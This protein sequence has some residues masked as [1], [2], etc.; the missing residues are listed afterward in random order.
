MNLELDNPFAVTKATEFS[1]LEIYKQWVDYTD[2]NTSLYNLLNPRELMPKFILGSKGCGKTH[3]LRYYSYP[4]QKLKWSE[5][6]KA[7]TNEKYI[8]IYTVFGGIN[9]SRFSGKGIEDEQW[10]KIFEYY[11]ELY[12]ASKLLDTLQ[13]VI[14]NL[15]IPHY[16]LKD[17]FINVNNVILKNLGEYEFSTLESVVEYLTKARNHIDFIVNNAALT[18]DVNLSTIQVRFNP[19]DLIFGIPKLFSNELE[20]FK[21][22][23][24]VYILDE[25]EKFN[26]YQKRYIN[27]LVWDKQ[28][29]CTFWIGA[30]YYGYTTKKTK[31]QEELRQGSEF[32]LI[33]LD[34]FLRNNETQYVK[35]AKQLCYK[36]IT[37]HIIKKNIR[38]DQES[39]SKALDEFFEYY[40]EID[41]LKLATLSYKSK[42][43]PHIEKLRRKLEEGL[44]NGTANGVKNSIDIEEIIKR[45]HFPENLISEKLKIFFFYKLWAENKNLIRAS[46]EINEEF[47]NYQKGK[48][49]KFD[50]LV[51]K[52]RKDLIAQLLYETGNKTLYFS[53]IDD[54]IDI[55]WGNP[56]SL[57]VILK[58]I[59]QWSS[60]YGE[61]PFREGLI[62][63]KAQNE[64]I[65]DASKW[66]YEDAE[67]IG[68]DGKNLYI[69]ITNLGEYLRG[70]RY[71]DKPSEISVV[72]FFL[73]KNNL[74]D[75]ANRY[76][77]LAV[78]HSFLIKIEDGRK[79]KNSSRVDDLYQINKMLAPLYRLP[80]ARRGTINL[81]FELAES[82]FNPDKHKDFSRVYKEAIAKMTAPNFGRKKKTI[83]ASGGLFEDDF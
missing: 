12:L 68:P 25:L 17:I 33:K 59:Y 77:K 57:L 55:S 52:S 67:V 42:E 44:K 3:L 31:T 15:E 1:D 54:L 24:F 76:L 37:K 61:K 13:D 71:S 39:L 7:L 2:N 16:K 60:F 35:F 70:I 32:E 66:F 48:K 56:R 22:L 36:R 6:N 83:K 9:S 46:Q 40:E 53:G 29:P 4:I 62:S 64:G 5:V 82:I 58:K 65:Y 50:N 10:E 47:S 81:N 74:S 8:G 38:N 27:T 21:D 28:Y 51:E 41:L 26:E 78:D 49:S 19:G 23:K 43:L 75:A 63:A 34:E 80:I 79:D 20:E 73:K 72:A 11:L 18:R 14:R 69:C 30:R 45:L